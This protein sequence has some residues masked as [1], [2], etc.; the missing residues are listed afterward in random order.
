L[1]QGKEDQQFID[2]HTVGW[3]KFRQRILEF[4]P[5]R[6]AAMTGLP[7]QAIIDLGKRL[8]ETRPTSI[9]IGIGL[10]RHGGG[11]M[12]VRTISCIPGVTGDWRYQAA[13]FSTTRAASLG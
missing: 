7:T 12:A 3:E 6:A 1:T 4:P 10:Q 2:E 8:A 11:G 9:R 13:E 5:S